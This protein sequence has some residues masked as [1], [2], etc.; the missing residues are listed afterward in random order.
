MTETENQIKEIHGM[1]TVLVSDST[2][3]K[4][5]LYGNGQPG[6]VKDLLE[7]QVNQR[8]CKGKQLGN[9]QNAMLATAII[10]SGVAIISVLVN[11]FKQPS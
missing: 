7:V 9:K 3:V 4:K 5:T 2:A 1:M 11:F 10:S 8:N 6:V